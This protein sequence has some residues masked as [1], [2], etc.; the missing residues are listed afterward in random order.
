MKLNEYFKSLNKVYHITFNPNTLSVIRIHLIPPKHVKMG[1][2]WVVLING[3][4]ILPI[5][6]G[7]A[8]LLKEFI[9]QANTYNNYNLN[10]E[11][12]ELVI[13]NTIKIV[14]EIFPKTK[15]EILI[16]DLKDIIQTISDIALGIVPNID[17]GYMKIKEYGKHMQAPHRMD[18]MISS[19]MK[20]NMWNCNQKCLHCYANT[21]ENAIVE[22][23]DTQQWKDIIDKLKDACIP[24]ITFTGGEPTLRDDLIELVKYSEYFVTR[25][26]TNGVEL[27]LKLAKDLYDASLDSIQITL[28][29]SKKEIHN[30]LVGSNKFNETINGIKNAIA[31]KLNVSI[32]TP[33][34]QINK[35][36][37]ETI[38]FAQQLGVRYFTCSG[39]IMTGGASEDKAMNTY[40]NKEE[41]LQIIKEVALYCKENFLEL[42]FTS[43]GWIEE[44]E[45]EKLGLIIPNCGACMSNMAIAPNGNVI[46]CQ[47]WL[48][49]NSLGNLNER[50]F[51][52]IWNS[53]ECKKIRK[54]VAKSN[55]K[56]L[57]AK[58]EVL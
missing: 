23:L 24:Q 17:I 34:C 22:E 54:I 50:S 2:S 16:E 3:Q 45:L 51:N 8:I 14:K 40:L 11:D 20:N 26:N 31:A 47:S 28:Y 53:K 35:D 13:N 4:D 18:L 58:V 27:S 12:I 52:S 46:P 57:L 56:C 43:P 10:D 42:S 49:N 41:I 5:T 7:W 1:I 37:L 38:K 48:T 44:K 32:N 15:E 9:E 6:T 30:I 55:N 39:I 36:Y 21:Q 29:S 25:V 19:M 33:L